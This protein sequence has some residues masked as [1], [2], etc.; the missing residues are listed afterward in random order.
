MER[1]KLFNK[2]R[3]LPQYKS[4]TEE[5]LYKKVDEYLQKDELLGSL[6]F[7]INSEER[8]FA[9]SLLDRYLEESSLESAAE[10]D[11]LR[12]L[13]DLEILAERYKTILRKEYEKTNPAIPK[14]DVEQLRETEKQILELK[15]SLGLSKRE[16]SNTLEEWNLLYK[17][18]LTYYKENAGCNVAKCPYCKR[19][20]LIMKD[21]RGHTTEK[22]TFFK[23]TILYNKEM[24]R[25]YEEQKVTREE[26]A[27]AFGV[28]PEFID[29]I[30]E[31]IYKNDKVQEIINAE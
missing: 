8:K 5:E 4:L 11:T 19:L 14:D 16:Q 31:D 15:D 24:Y 9:Q 27:T 25:W 1:E 30:Y 2:Y 20:Y 23:K 10:K 18:A 7:A 29:L 28:A 26:M 21:M 13:I 22:V 12:Q 3:N 6:N 17:K